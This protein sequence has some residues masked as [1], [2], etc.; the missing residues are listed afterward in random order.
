MP[1]TLSA[2]VKSDIRVPEPTPPRRRPRKKTPPRRWVREVQGI[3]ALTAGLF[4]FVALVVF[5]PT[6]APSEQTSVVG[7]VGI[8]L[9]WAC[10]RAFGYAAFLFP[11]AA[12][13]WGGS[14]FVRPLAA[15]GLAPV[16]GLL[17]LLL[18]AA[19]LLQQATDSMAAARV[20]RGGTVPAGGFTGWATAAVLHST[21][22]DA[23]AWLLLVTA[24]PVAALLVTRTS[25]AAVVRLIAARLARLRK[26]RAASLPAVA[27]RALA[28]VPRLDEV[29]AVDV[30]PALRGCRRR[31]RSPTSRHRTSSC[32]Y[33]RSSSPRAP[34]AR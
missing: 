20:T 34:R 23:G 5:D 32:R 19:A 26:R 13:V 30:E 2:D 12:G 33:R 22:G 31:C 16:V 24:V 27:T 21:V 7:P 29:A 8:W 11:L 9:A 17:L 10:F 3:M 14:A 18:A 6:V 15:R 1:A 4:V 28:V 25:Y